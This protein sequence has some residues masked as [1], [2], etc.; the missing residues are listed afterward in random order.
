MTDPAADLRSRVRA[1]MLAHWRPDGHTVPNAAVYPW[2][3][4]W[5]SCFHSIIWAELGEPERAVTELRSALADQDELGFVPHV[6]Y[7]GAPSPHALFWGRPVTSSITQPPLYGHAVAELERRGITVPDDVR[8]R[9][10]RGVQFLLRHRRRTAS[11]LVTAVHPWETGCDDSPRWGHWCPGAWDVRRWYDVK[12]ALLK[13]V[14]RAR[15][16]APLAN[17]AFGVA[18]AGFNALVAWNAHELGLDSEAAELADALAARWDRDLMTWV[19][20]GPSADTS[21]R[22]RTVDSLLPALVVPSTN[23]CQRSA[24]HGALTDQAAFGAPFGPAS[25]HRAEPTFDPRG[26]WRGSSW[27]QLSYLLWRSGAPGLGPSLVHGAARSGLAEHWHP[28][29][30]EGLGARPQSWAGLAILVPGG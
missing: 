7:V 11:D 18:P 10:V 24:A 29:T 9:A 16:G 25:V 27:P 3:W 20:D 8:E 19:D 30:A 13:T 28:D 14:E 1:M 17:P 6:R 21:G 4:L 23:E 2:Q 22:V 15:G 26:Y 12:G 5:D